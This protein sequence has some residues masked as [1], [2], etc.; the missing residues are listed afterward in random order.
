DPSIKVVLYFNPKYGFD[1]NNWGT[2]I[3][4]AWLLRDNKGQLMKRTTKSQG[5]QDF[6]TFID[7]SNPDYR[8]WAISVLADWL[9]S[10][11]YAGISFDEAAPI[12]LGNDNVDFTS[13]LGQQRIDAYNDGIRDLLGRATQLAGPKREGIFN[14]IDPGKPSQNVQLL[15]YTTGALTEYFCIGAAGKLADVAT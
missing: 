6:A 4:P 11:P 7:L 8:N 13:R 10:A 15:D 14:G 2:Q 12:G 1:Q 3:N 5:E 9:K